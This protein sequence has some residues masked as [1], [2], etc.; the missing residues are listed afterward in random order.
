MLNSYIL[1]ILMVRKMC[2]E[3]S[4]WTS[5]RYYTFIGNVQ[6]FI[7]SQQT[8]VFP[9]SKLQLIRVL[10]LVHGNLTKVFHSLFI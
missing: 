1:Y 6:V 7:R 3:L 4:N 5:F 2:V 10:I 9:P 8:S